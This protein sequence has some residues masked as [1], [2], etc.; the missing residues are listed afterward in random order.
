MTLPLAGRGR[1]LAMSHTEDE[2][3]AFAAWERAAWEERAIPYAASITDLTEGAAPGLLDAA[4]V[5][6]GTS[7]LDVA[8]GPG[9]VASLAIGRGARVT[10][11]D[12]SA[13]MVAL[14]SSALPDVTVTAASAELLP[15]ADGTFGAVVAGFLLNHLARPAT[16]VREM[17]RV[18]D[19]G[20]RVALSVWDRPE[21]NPALGLFGPVAQSLGATAVVPPGPESTVYADDDALVAL[22]ADAGLTD[23]QVERVNWDVDVE[24]GAWFDAVAAATPRT[25]AVLARA[26][27]STR[28][29]LR[30]RYTRTALESFA[31]GAGRVC[32]PAT[33]VIGS[34][35]R[36]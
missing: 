36:P 8:T 22:L 20:G 10:A 19:A 7:L 13:A 1:L 14:A 30:D 3:E 31:V 23:I 15:F 27:T 5:T 26:T 28:D 6:A 34:G 25:G 32:L 33:A 18:L 17:T 2:L 9:V 35:S 4:G 11:V 21:A 12:Q 16:G 29:A 24:P